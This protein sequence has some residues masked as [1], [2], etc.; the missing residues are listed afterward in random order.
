[1]YS[2][3]SWYFDRMSPYLFW[4]NKYIR[5]VMQITVCALSYLIYYSPTNIR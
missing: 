1:M 4:I 5:W 2:P 3:C